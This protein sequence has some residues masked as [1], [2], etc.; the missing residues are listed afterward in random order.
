M[1]LQFSV[2][3]V[4]SS[5]LQEE[6]G[7]A[8][9]VLKQSGAADGL[10]SSNGWRSAALGQ[11]ECSSL[12]H[13]EH[14]ASTRSLSFP[15]TD[16]RERAACAWLS[17]GKVLKCFWDLR[18][19]IREFCMK[20]GNPIPQLSDADWLSDLGFAVDV[21][22]QMNELNVKLQS[23]G[24]FV[25]EM[26]S[27]VKAFM[28]KLEFLS[29]QMRENI[30]THMP[31]LKEVNPSAEHLKSVNDAP[32]DVQ[33]ELIDLQ[34]DTLLAEKFRSVPLNEFYSSLKEENFPHMRRHAQKILVLFGSTYVCE[35]TFSVMKFNKSRYRSS[36]TD[37]H[38][39]AVLRIV[40]SDIEPDFNALVQAQEDWVFLT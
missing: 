32:S 14:L 4:Q 34:S 16:M 31:T 10:V 24:L 36:M 35:Q 39:S 20:K 7:V 6:H 25:Y 17:L 13:S 1:S 23:K 11:S 8:L 21:T 9:F 28:R 19:E 22:A 5:L 37:D 29:S 15:L 3:Q 18:E 33:M 2:E 27:A 30:L 40:T 38:L 26:Y 12:A